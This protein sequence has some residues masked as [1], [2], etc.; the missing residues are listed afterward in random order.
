MTVATAIATRLLELSAVTDLVGTRVRVLKLRQ[1]E[2]LPAI[3]VQR[4]STTEQMHERG[5][6]GMFRSRVQVDSV[7][8][9]ASGLDPYATA[10]SVD[11]AVH[12]DGAGSGL[13][14]WQGEIGSPAFVIDAILPDGLQEMYEPD[15]SKQVRVIRDYIVWHRG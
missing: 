9:E 14:G 13:C 3:R 7:A 5:S 12:G 1:T 11:D 15:T 6:V 4:I 8:L 10:A 2:T